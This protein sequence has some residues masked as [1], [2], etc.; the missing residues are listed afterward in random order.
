MGGQE[1]GNSFNS[2]VGFVRDKAIAESAADCKCPLVC[3]CLEERQEWHS[4]HG[5]RS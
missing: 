2:D 5:T 3:T 4:D 1:D